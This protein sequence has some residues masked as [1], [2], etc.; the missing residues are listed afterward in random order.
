MCEH[1]RKHFKDSE[2]ASDMPIHNGTMLYTNICSN[3]QVF[4]DAH[5]AITNVLHELLDILWEAIVHSIRAALERDFAAIFATPPTYAEFE[6]AVKASS[7]NT[8]P[9]LSRVTNNMFKCLP[10]SMSMKVY[11]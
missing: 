10:K 2:M 5:H 3:R 4:I 1:F 6:A 7:T 11:E 9:G 8:S